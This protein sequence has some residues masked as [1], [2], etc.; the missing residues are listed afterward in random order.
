MRLLAVVVGLLVVSCDVGTED[1]TVIGPRALYVDTT[2]GSGGVGGGDAGQS[3]I[4]GGGVIHDRMVIVT[5]KFDQS[6]CCQNFS[7]NGCTQCRVTRCSPSQTMALSVFTA[8]RN[9]EYRNCSITQ[10]TSD[11]FSVV[12]GS[13]EIVPTVCRVNGRNVNDNDV[14]CSGVQRSSCA[15]FP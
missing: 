6:F 5:L 10:T 13:C 8:L 12:C 14:S 1:F 11:G 2:P 3:G 9:K 15:F 7:C 4:G